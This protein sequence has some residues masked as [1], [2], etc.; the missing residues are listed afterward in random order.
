MPT[1]CIET[2]SG[3]QGTPPSCRSVFHKELKMLALLVS[4]LTSHT[5]VPTL[6]PKQPLKLSHTH[7]FT[8]TT[9]NL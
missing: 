2:P 1:P 9:F 5:M 3:R 7:D 6:K 4:S 8:H